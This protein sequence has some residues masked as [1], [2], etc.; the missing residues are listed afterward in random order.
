MTSVLDTVRPTW[1][2]L[3]VDVFWIF[4]LAAAFCLPYVL[5][6][7]TQLYQRRQKLLKALE[8]F[9]SLPMHCLYGHTQELQDQK[10][11]KIVSWSQKY[12]RA[13]PLWYGGF[14]G[15]LNIYHLEYA[16]AVYSRED[17]KAGV[18]GYDFF[19]PWLGRGLLLLHG[20]KWFQHRQLL[21]TAFRNGVLKSYVSLMVDSTKAMLDKW[22]KWTTKHKSLDTSGDIA[23]M[24]LDSI[25]KCMF[26]YKSNCQNRTTTF[27][28]IVRELTAMIQQKMTSFLYHRDLIY[29]FTPQGCYFWNL[30]KLV[31][32]HSEEVI[33]ERKEW[34]KDQREL[35]K[36]KKKR[37]LNFL[38]SLLCAKFGAVFCTQFPDCDAIS[39]ERTAHAI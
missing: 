30:R 10:L 6:K 38:D 13:H 28:R 32:A 21:S 4:Y 15:C 20:P 2:W 35:E 11:D 22:E 24:A 14:L 1:V 31:H 9:P 34:L 3:H 7:V 18:L 23:L 33:R 17:P 16:K 37:H 39:S 8:C 27:L 29:R 19:L 12:P 5:L 26:G 25:L 36:I